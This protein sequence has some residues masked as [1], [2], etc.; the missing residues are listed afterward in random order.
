MKGWN[1]E[2]PS[3]FSIGHA[4]APRQPFLLCELAGGVQVSAL[5]DTGSMKSILSES[6]F[7]QLLDNCT[8]QN[9]TL[10]VF[11][12]NPNQCV[13]V[14]GQPL[15]SIGSVSS[16]LSFPSSDYSYDCQFMVCVNVLQPPQCILGWDFL[17]A[18]NLQLSYLGDSYALVGPHGS[19]PLI[20]LP[21]TATSSS[22]PFA[23]GTYT[24]PSP[25]RDRDQPVFS[26]S[27]SQG[28]VKVTL[29]TSITIPAR[30]ECIVEAKVPPS[31]HEQLG[32]V[33]QK[34]ES[35]E[36]DIINYCIAYTVSQAHERNIPVRIM[37]PSNHPIELQAGQT[38]AEFCPVS[39]VVLMSSQSQSSGQSDDICASV[40][41]P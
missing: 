39:E 28:P 5:I 35:A 16:C 26:Q 13:S 3:V 17:T 10:P 34:G 8:R 24:H 36:S 18:H 15:R 20:P 12:S 27:S 2:H 29:R 25:G 11:R 33:S 14:T 23:A 21:Y 40:A 4:S 9:K 37:N 22:D 7:R 6:L 41:G 31:C 30:V 38:I 1:D 32:M 19:T